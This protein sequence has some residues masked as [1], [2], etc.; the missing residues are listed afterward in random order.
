ML[1]IRAAASS[2][3][4]GI[5]SSARQIRCTASALAAVTENPGLTARARCS[6]SSTDAYERSF[7]RRPVRR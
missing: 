3:A 4:S 6:N 1:R 5:P 7:R 2:I